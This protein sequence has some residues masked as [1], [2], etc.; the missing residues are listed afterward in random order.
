MQLTHHRTVVWGDTGLGSRKG[1][2]L[3]VLLTRKAAVYDVSVPDAPTT[4]Q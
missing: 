1:V 4:R 3:A 2:V